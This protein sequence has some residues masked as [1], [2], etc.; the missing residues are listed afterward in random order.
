ME[1]KSP[2]PE[3]Q[4]NKSLFLVTIP[5][6]RQCGFWA[7]FSKLTK[8]NV[9]TDMFCT[10]TPQLVQLSK[11]TVTDSSYLC[12]CLNSKVD[13]PI[14]PDDAVL[15]LCLSL[16]MTFCQETFL[17]ESLYSINRHFNVRL[18]P[19]ITKLIKC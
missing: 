16:Q 6:L 13:Q 5:I 2:L 17:G 4:N 12:Y 10:E 7:G 18:N 11:R 15:G 14:L 3:L 1:H 19:K 8:D 9:I